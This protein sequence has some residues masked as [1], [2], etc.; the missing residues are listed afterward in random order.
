[1]RRAHWALIVASSVPCPTSAAPHRINPLVFRLRQDDAA[2]RV[3]RSP[4]DSR[5]LAGSYL[6][7][8]GFGDSNR[9]DD[10]R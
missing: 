8:T 10:D 2:R 6:P 3:A 4:T 9:R 7:A 1:M 5:S